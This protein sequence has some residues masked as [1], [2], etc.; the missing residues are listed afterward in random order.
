M[1]TEPSIVWNP[2]DQDGSLTVSL[3]VWLLADLI[4]GAT[5]RY[6]AGDCYT[7]SGLTCGVW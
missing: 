3:L 6:A 7:G 4:R 2:C 5:V 1:S